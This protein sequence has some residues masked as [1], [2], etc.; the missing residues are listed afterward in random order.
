MTRCEVVEVR[1]LADTVGLACSRT[2]STQ[3]SDCGSELC[4]SHTETRWRQHGHHSVVMSNMTGTWQ[5][6]S[7]SSVFEYSLMAGQCILSRKDVVTKIMA[8]VHLPSGTTRQENA[9]PM[10]A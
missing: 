2:A 1:S 10:T 5:L 7:D 6:N 9:M 4:G 3:C 8:A